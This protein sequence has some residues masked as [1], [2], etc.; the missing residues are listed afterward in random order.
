MNSLNF[1][2]RNIIYIISVI[3][4]FVCLKKLKEKILT[5]ESIKDKHLDII[6]FI[7]IYLNYSI[8][9]F[10][11]TA[12][13]YGKNGNFTFVMATCLF[14]ILISVTIKILS[15][16][17]S[18]FIINELSKNI[19]DHVATMLNPL[20]NDLS[21]NEQI[22]LLNEQNEITANKLKILKF[23]EWINRILKNNGIVLLTSF[24]ISTLISYFII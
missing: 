14:T 19:L 21:I 16:I 5:V 3:I 4:V 7:F 11:A 20:N 6:D 22:D 13:I 23:I 10:L 17:L 8:A 12:I 18:K 1:I 15:A 9:I 24:L 2:Q